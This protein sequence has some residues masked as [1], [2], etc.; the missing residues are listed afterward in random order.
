MLR[1]QRETNL[2]EFL[3]TAD[4]SQPIYLEAKNVTKIV[5]NMVFNL[6]FQNGACHFC[7]LCIYIV[8]VK[9]YNFCEVWLLLLK[10][11]PCGFIVFLIS[12]N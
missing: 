10:H 4:I 11:S 1:S 12:L 2:Q 9:K 3:G 7:T 5:F 6:G 8:I